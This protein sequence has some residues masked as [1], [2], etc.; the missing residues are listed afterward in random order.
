MNFI[1]KQYPFLQFFETYILSLVQ[2]SLTE[3][4]HADAEL[5]KFKQAGRQ[6]GQTPKQ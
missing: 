5:L 2:V 6:A 3:K 4:P 1:Y